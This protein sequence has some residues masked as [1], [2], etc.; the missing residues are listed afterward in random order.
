VVNSMIASDDVVDAGTEDQD[1][2]PVAAYLGY[3]D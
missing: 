1:D 2:D 3:Y